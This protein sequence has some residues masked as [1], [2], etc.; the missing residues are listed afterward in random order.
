MRGF[1]VMEERGELAGID[2]LL[3]LGFYAF[4]VERAGGG[5]SAE[6]GVI[7]ERYAFAGDDFALFVLEK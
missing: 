6:Q 3:F 2:D 7:H 1:Q 5:A 4:A